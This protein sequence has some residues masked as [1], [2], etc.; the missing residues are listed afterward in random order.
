LLRVIRH[1]SAQRW[2]L[3]LG[4]AGAGVFWCRQPVGIL[5]LGTL[6]VIALALHGTGW[7]PAHHSK[8][9]LVLWTCAGLAGVSMVQLGAIIFS[10]AAPAW[11]HQN[12]VWPRQWAMSSSTVTWRIVLKVFLHPPTGAVLLGLGLAAVLPGLVR[13]FR[14]AFPTRGIL[15]YY[16]F[17][18]ATLVW[19][20]ERVLQALAWRD[21]GWSLVLPLVVLLQS[22]I[23]L[24]R[25]FAARAQPLPAEYHLVAACAALSLGSLGQYYPVPDPWHVFWSLA[26]A[27]GL[28]VYAFWRWSGWPAPVVAGVIVTTL[29]PSLYAKI[30]LTDGFLSQPLVTL[31][32]PSALRGLRVPPP[33]AAAYDQIVRA[34]DPILKHQPDIPSVLIGQDPLYLCFAPNRTNPSP[35]FVTWP[36]LADQTANQQRW[37][38]VAR[39]RPLM[40]LQ[41]VDRAATADFYRRARYFPLAYVPNLALEIAVPQEL[42]DQLGL[43]ADGGARE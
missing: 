30:Q 43:K 19:Q 18:A 40:F 29:L 37:D 10:G 3:I 17:F 2:A 6:S 21:G 20:R 38:F 32:A 12:F 5:M 22:I 15:V 36:G 27:F 1:E 11:W 8:K 31:T 14:P 34:L 13:R 39:V 7:R 42:A 33:Q 35:Y 24:T 9:N 41:Q 26:P 4:L 16:V 23:S 28:C 25:G